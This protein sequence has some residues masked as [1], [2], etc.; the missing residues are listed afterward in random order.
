MKSLMFTCIDKT[1][2]RTMKMNLRSVH[3]SKVHTESL[4]LQELL[5]QKHVE[6][7]VAQLYIYITGLKV[8]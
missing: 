1:F 7:L 8:Y 3:S 2:E 4:A 6:R 5:S